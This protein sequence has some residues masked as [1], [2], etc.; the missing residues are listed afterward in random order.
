MTLVPK[1]QENNNEVQIHNPFS[2]QDMKDVIKAASV[3]IYFQLFIKVL[4]TLVGLF[5]FIVILRSISNDIEREIQ[6]N[7]QSENI[8]REK[9]KK[10]YDDNLCARENVPPALRGSCDAWRICM[11]T[12]PSGIGR[13]RAAARF[14][15]QLINELVNPLSPKAIVL[16][17]LAVAGY[18]I[19]HN[20]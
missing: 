9:C 17:A 18:L 16:M 15:A 19:V 12:A 5:L 4:I 11:N 10:E 8:E 6:K 13:T 2:N 7:I 14:C 20:A 3:H 1:Q